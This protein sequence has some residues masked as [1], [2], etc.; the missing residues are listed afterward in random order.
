MPFTVHHLDIDGLLLFEPLKFSDS[1]GWFAEYYRESLFVD[2]GIEAPFV[3][4]NVSFSIRGVI[5]GLHYQVPPAEQAKLVTVLE[6]EIFDV[7]V[8]MRAHSPTRSRWTGL[9]LDAGKGHMLYI[10]E[11]F[12]HGFAVLSDS[13]VVHYKCTAEYQPEYERGIRW[14]D[15]DLAI[16]WP[17]VDPIMSDKDLRLPVMSTHSDGAMP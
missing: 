15:P 8:D 3:Q 14:N 1:R 11:G 4:D 9:R 2:A 7:A 12:A 5:R 13:A 10:P 16:A 6:G 17:V